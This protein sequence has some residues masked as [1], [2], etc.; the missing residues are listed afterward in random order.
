[1]NDPV[2]VLPVNDLRE[3][4]S[5]GIGCE[6]RPRLIDG[7]AVIVHNSFDGREITERAVDDAQKAVN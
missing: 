4:V 7:G 1:M 6:C 5:E 2:H 3:H